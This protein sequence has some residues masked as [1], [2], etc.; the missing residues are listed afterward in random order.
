MNRFLKAEKLSFVFT[1]ERGGRNGK[2]NGSLFSPLNKKNKKGNCNF[3]SHSE[4]MSHNSDF[5]LQDINLQ[6]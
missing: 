2:P 3:V 1:S 4:F 5:I 6:F